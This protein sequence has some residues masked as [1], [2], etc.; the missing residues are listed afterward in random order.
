MFVCVIVNFVHVVIII[1]D[2][3][4]VHKDS[5]KWPVYGPVLSPSLCGLD[6]IC[7]FHLHYNIRTVLL[8]LKKSV[9]QGPEQAFKV[10]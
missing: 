2:S 8:S 3:A 7:L 9:Y 10:F 5:L 1:V 6:Q 4:L